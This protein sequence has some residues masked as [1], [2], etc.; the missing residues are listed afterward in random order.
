MVEVV[1]SPVEIQ[2]NIKVVGVGG[3]GCNAINR[4]YKDVYHD[5]HVTNQVEFIAA[6]TDQQA[7]RDCVAPIKLHLGNSSIHGAGDDPIVGKNA[8][9]EVKDK[10]L[11]YIKNTHTLILCAGMGGGTGTGA[12]PVI[13]KLAKEYDPNM[14]VIAVVTKPFE[15]EYKLEKAEKGIEE[16]RKYTDAVFIIPNQRIFS[17]VPKTTPIEQA[18]RKIDSYLESIIKGITY[19]ITKK[20]VV[21][22]DLSDLRTVLKNSK[23]VWYGIGECE[24]EKGLRYS[25]DL[26][27]R[28]KLLE[29][30]RIRNVERVLVLIEGDVT[31]GDFEDLDRYIRE[32]IGNSKRPQCKYGH[33]INDDEKSKNY[34][35]VI[36]I[37]TNSNNPI[38]EPSLK[39]FDPT[40]PPYLNI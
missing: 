18:R 13:A 40:R 14:L 26:A 1:F 25:F 35:R 27:T 24:K 30:F 29:E 11:E 12:T 7:L 16:L 23:Y 37:G 10:I 21:N 15:Y 31:T 36:L 32:I 22:I 9:L 8:A 28:S 5:N 20:G 33:V 3:C 19:I 6:N 17:I 39:K 4:I 2:P 34:Y 38:Y